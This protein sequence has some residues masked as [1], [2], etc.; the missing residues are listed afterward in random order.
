[1]SDRPRSCVEGERAA[2]VI[3]AAWGLF[4][5]A[6]INR[7]IEEIARLASLSAGTTRNYLSAAVTKLGASN[8]HDAVA[9]ARRLGWI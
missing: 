9:V 5:L 7:E 6:R 8:R 3:Q 1:M 4:R 2:L